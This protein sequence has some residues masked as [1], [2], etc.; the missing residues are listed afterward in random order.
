MCFSSSKLDRNIE[1]GLHGVVIRSANIVKRLFDP[2]H[3]VSFA[4]IALTILL[5]L[6]CDRTFLPGS[7]TQN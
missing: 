2:Q 4:D 5:Q 3:C 6:R 7:N 1:A